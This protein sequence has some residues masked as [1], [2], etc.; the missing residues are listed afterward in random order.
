MKRILLLA[1]TAALML[2]GC[3]SE[4]S[5][6]TAADGVSFD[7]VLSTRRSIRSYDASKTISESEV[8][9]ILLATQDAPSWANDQPSKYYV[10]MSP[11]KI[12]AIQELIAIDRDFYS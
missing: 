3:S 2:T 12:A 6:T 4:T 10:A 8:R 9:E 1:A 5:N 11:E 7:E